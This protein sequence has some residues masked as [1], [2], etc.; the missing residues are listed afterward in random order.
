MTALCNHCRAEPWLLGLAIGRACRA[1]YM[2]A[3]RRPRLRRQRP[4][5]ENWVCPYCNKAHALYVLV[6]DCIKPRAIMVAPPKDA[7]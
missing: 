6:C 3:W 4:R 2:R 5:A 7:A 1:A